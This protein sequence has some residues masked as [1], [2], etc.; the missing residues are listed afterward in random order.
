MVYGKIWHTSE[1][2]GDD[3]MPDS[4]QN[5]FDNDREAAAF[6]ATLPMFVQDQ[7]RAKAEVVR[8]REE[9]ASL[10]NNIAREGVKLSQYRSVFEDET[11]SEIDLQ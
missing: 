3:S 9:L 2:K 10:A 6:F 5:L 1:K 11:D 4:L 8:T 7:V